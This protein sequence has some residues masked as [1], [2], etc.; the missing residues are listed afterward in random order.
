VSPTLLRLFYALQLASIAALIPLLGGRFEQAGLSGG[1]I[2]F[3]MAMLPLGRLI[4]T[5]L[6]AFVADRY[7]LAG[8]ILRLACVTSAAAGVVLARAE[9]V[10]VIAAAMFI[11]ASLRAPIGAI[12]DSFVMNELHRTGQPSSEYGRIRLFGS[13]GFVVSVVLASWLERFGVP[14]HWLA[15]LTLVMAAV[16][17]FRFPL[18]GQGGPAPVL[19]ALRALVQQPFLIPL[20]LGGA[21]QALTL[22]V[23]D[24]F[25]SVHIAALGLPSV[26]VGACVGIGVAGEMALMAFGRGI[27][28]RISPATALLLAAATGVP[29]WLLTAVATDPAVLVLA[30]ALHAVGFAAF[31]LAGVQRMAEAS[32]PHITASAQSLWG[33]STYGLGALVGAILAGAV[34]GEWGSESIFFLLAG[35]ATLATLCALWMRAVDDQRSTRFRDN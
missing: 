33:A 10:L 8:V 12:L 35:C 13:L 32:P 34:L 14:S 26:V 6:W 29:R 7:Q 3:L 17:A 21:F 20:L 15:D 18:A 27:F 23:Y 19:P 9:S 30:Q 28:A 16:L 5:P 4:A 22:S 11:F 1:T 2:G 24:T 31:W 25:L